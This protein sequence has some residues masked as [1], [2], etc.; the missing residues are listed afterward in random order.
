MKLTAR[1][2]AIINHGS[3]KVKNELLKQYFDIINDPMVV[4]YNKSG[5]FSINDNTTGDVK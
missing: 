3:L 2:E 5:V 4:R 1:Q